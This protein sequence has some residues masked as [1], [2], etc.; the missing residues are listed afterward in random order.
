M[1]IKYLH[2]LQQQK[3]RDENNVFIAEGIKTVSDIISLG[4]TPKE[5]YYTDGNKQLSSKITSC[6]EHIPQSVM[7]RISGL[8]TPQ[9]V[10]A[11]FKKFNY[12][13]LDLS[14]TNDK[15][16]L[17]LDNISDPGNL[18]TIIRTADWFGRNTIVCSQNTVDMYN[19]KVV[20]A[21]MGAIANIR[22]YYVDTEE[23]LYSARTNGMNIYGTFMEGEDIRTAKFTEQ[24]VIIIGNEANG[25]SETAKKHITHRITIPDGNKKGIHSRVSESLNAAVSAAIVL[26]SC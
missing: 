23:F 12:P 11:V 2:S 7:S 18:G 22:I 20:Q 25:I 8:K 14:E 6:G 17:F 3:F 4:Y 21:T 13:P 5:L 24:S 10:F 1:N 26:F 16:I 19:P 9:Q 15:H